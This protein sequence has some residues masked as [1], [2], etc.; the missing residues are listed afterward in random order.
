MSRTLGLRERTGH[1]TVL[2]QFDNYLY[3]FSRALA[4]MILVRGKVLSHLRSRRGIGLGVLPPVVSLR[5]CKCG[6]VN[7]GLQVFSEDFVI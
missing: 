7:N 6:N 5:N 3:V 2:S 1:W 4:L